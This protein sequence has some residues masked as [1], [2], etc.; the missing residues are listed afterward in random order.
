MITLSAFLFAAVYHAGAAEGTG[1]A[2][3]LPTRSAVFVN[4]LQVTFQAYNV[5]DYNYFKLRDLA[6]A[7]DGSGKQFEVS[8]DEANNTVQ[9]TTGKAY[10]P[11]GGELTTTGDAAAKEA[12]VSKATVFINGVKV[13]LSAYL[14]DGFNYFK[15]RDIA[16]AVG[17][18]VTYDETTTDIDIDTDDTTTDDDDTTPKTENPLIGTWRLASQETEYTSQL[19]LIFSGDGRLVQFIG[20]KVATYTADD[21]NVYVTKVK[22]VYSDTYSYTVTASGGQTMLDI[23]SNQFGLMVRDGAVSGTGA[24]A[25]YGLWLS[26]NTNFNDNTYFYFTKDGSVLMGVTLTGVYT[27]SDTGDAF[28]DNITP[29]GSQKTTSFVVTVKDGVTQMTTTDSQ[30]RQTTMYKE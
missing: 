25:L 12:I 7:L 29:D 17:F 13:G 9:I 10:T 3:A 1:A 18:G 2:A 14:I 19:Y 27:L 4:G 6:K 8:Y 11:V 20:S 15:L 24:E 23:D 21:S 22:V 5:H 30:G 16:A 28:T 26:K